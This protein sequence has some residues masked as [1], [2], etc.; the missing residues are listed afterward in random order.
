MLQNNGEIIR[1]KTSFKPEKLHYLLHFLTVK[2]FNVTSAED[3]ESDPLDPQDFGFLDPDP[4]KYADPRIRI[5]GAKYQ[6]KT[7]TKKNL[8]SKPKSELLKKER[9]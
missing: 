4:Q 3:P 5:Q 8:I 9:I 2:S 1:K 7:A 6:P